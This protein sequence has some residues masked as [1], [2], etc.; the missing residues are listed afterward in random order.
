MHLVML[1]QVLE[2]SDKGKSGSSKA[3]EHHKMRQVFFRMTVGV[4]LVNMV[5]FI[6]FDVSSVQF[7]LKYQIRERK[8]LLINLKSL[9]RRNKFIFNE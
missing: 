1:F 2:G 3:V 4:N 8:S 5:L 9:F 6:N 7:V